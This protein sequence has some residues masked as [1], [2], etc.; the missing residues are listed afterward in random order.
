M[1]ASS[2]KKSELKQLAAEK[3][4]TIKAAKAAKAA[5]KQAESETGAVGTLQRCYRGFRGREAYN[6][7]REEERQQQELVR[8]AEEERRQGIRDNFAKELKEL[9]QAR[10]SREK[11]VEVCGDGDPAKVVPLLNAKG[12]VSHTRQ[13]QS[14]ICGR[15]T[16]VLYIWDLPCD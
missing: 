6:G 12:G 9:Q 2:D 11:L 15:E 14:Y 13:G 1:L 7:R 16:I 10:S 4:E 5:A 3:A 8:Q